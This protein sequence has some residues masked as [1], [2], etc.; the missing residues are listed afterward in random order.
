MFEFAKFQLANLVNKPDFP[1]LRFL[2]KH[3]QYHVAIAGHT[4]T[5]GPESFNN[6]LSAQRAQEAQQFLL[7]NGI[8]EHRISI[9]AHGQSAPIADN[10]MKEGRQLNRRI[11]VE[12][13]IPESGSKE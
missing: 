2:E 5:T 12:F 7:D 13:Y 4:D 11:S 3:P 10:A 8:A 9:S 6:Q 1:A